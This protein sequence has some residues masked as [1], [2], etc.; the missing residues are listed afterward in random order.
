M[1]CTSISAATGWLSTLLLQVGGDS[2]H[3]HQRSH[4]VVQ[5]ADMCS[6][7]DEAIHIHTLSDV[8]VH[9][10]PHDLVGAQGLQQV[11]HHSPYCLPQTHG[12]SGALRTGL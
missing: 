12:V 1:V 6:A 4:R 5:I 11:L 9:G 3:Q 7:S 10:E 2:L 8:V